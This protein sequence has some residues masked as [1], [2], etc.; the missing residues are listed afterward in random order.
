METDNIIANQQRE[1]DDLRHEVTLLKD[2]ATPHREPA[3]NKQTLHHPVDLIM[4]NSN[5]VLFRRLAAK[6]P[7]KRKMEYVSPNILRFGYAAEDFISGEV[8]FR[9]LVYHKDSSRTLREIQEFTE[10]GVEEYE[11]Y[12][13]IVTKKGEA[14]WVEDRTS[15]YEDAMSGLRYHQ[16][17]VIDIHDRKIIE[18][19]LKK[20]EEKHRRVIETTAEGFLFLDNDFVTVDLSLAYERMVGLSRT[21]L[22]GR[23]PVEIT[24]DISLCLSKT[25]EN[26]RQKEIEGELTNIH[27]QKLP[28]LIPASPTNYSV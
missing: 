6:D 19:K 13:R 9:D 15:V 23:K 28:V 22:L 21:E 18:E 7:K 27:G 26:A 12:Y 14:R 24:P 8:M 17:I 3:Y 20:S 4:E 25:E 1:I 11:Q 2:A 16:G 10:Q 5:A